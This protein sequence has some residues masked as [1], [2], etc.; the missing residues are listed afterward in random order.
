MTLNRRLITAGNTLDD[1]AFG[2]GTEYVNAQGLLA[3]ETST[4]SVDEGDIEY[5]E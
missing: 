3:D 4:D 2:I 5:H 1:S